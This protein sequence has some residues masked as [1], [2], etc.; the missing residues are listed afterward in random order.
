MARYDGGWAPYVPV[1]KRRA[2]A[3]RQMKKLAKKGKTIT[4]V[5]ISGRKIAKTFWGAAWCKHL[6]SF[7]DFS[8]RLPRGQRYARNGSVCHL[9]ISK[10]KI[11][12]IVS[13]SELYNISITIGVL[14][15]E[16]WTV[17]REQCTGRIGSLLELLQGSFSDEVM[18]IVTD[19]ETGL[20]PQPG[21]IKLDC[22]CPDYA[23]MCKHVAATL[24]GVGTRLDSSPELLF[25][26]R[27]VDHEELISA[28]AATAVGAAVGGSRRRRRMKGDLSTVFGVDVEE[29]EPVTEAKKT[30][31]RAA[32]KSAKA[33][34]PAKK[35]TKKKAEPKEKKATLPEPTGK[36]IKALR[37]RFKMTQG[38]LGRLM[39]VSA[40]SI[41]SWEKKVSVLRLRKPT[42][43]AYGE[44]A[45]LTPKQAQTRLARMT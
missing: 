38:E 28:E 40:T 39:G 7:S 43:K 31:K 3:A 23:T 37:S 8:N 9:G 30:T 22:D 32:K 24:Y 42:L 41:C 10:G 16:K 6:E 5:E 34:T 13:G 27:G 1:A 19:R 25:T 21:E 14:P 36:R 4:P 12:A 2:Q 29:D 17:I 44:I 11:E 26:L 20:F 45:R 15:K 35:T 18:E 33:K